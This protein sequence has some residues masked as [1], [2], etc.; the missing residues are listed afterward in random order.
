MGWLGLIKVACKSFL[1]GQDDNF[2]DSQPA[3]NNAQLELAGAWAE[4]GNIENVELKYE[5][6]D[7]S[8]QGMEES[9]TLLVWKWNLRVV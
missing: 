9:Q 6:L 4:L 3:N 7:S 2:S 5:V 8:K 1:G